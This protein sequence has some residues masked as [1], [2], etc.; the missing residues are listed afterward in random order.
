MSTHLH[1]EKEPAAYFSQNDFWIAFFS[2]MPFQ[3]IFNRILRNISQLELLLQSFFLFSKKW[4]DPYFHKPHKQIYVLSVDVP[5]MSTFF[6]L[7]GIFFFCLIYWCCLL[8]VSVCVYKSTH[9]LYYMLSILCRSYIL[10][11]CFKSNLVS[12]ARNY[13]PYHFRSYHLLNAKYIA[14]I[15]SHWVLYLLYRTNIAF[16]W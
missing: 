10:P 4:V 9:K 11:N 2:F 13:H 15:S 1:P 7:A 3:I 16:Y 8:W 6:F 12:Q 5:F 14:C